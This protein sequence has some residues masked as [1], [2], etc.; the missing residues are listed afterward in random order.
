MSATW[1]PSNPILYMAGSEYWFW[2]VDRFN[3]FWATPSLY[4]MSSQPD[5]TITMTA[6]GAATLT[7]YDANPLASPG[8]YIVP[9]P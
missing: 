1:S 4:G 7:R 9:L 2:T 8:A 6:W 3:T 5:G